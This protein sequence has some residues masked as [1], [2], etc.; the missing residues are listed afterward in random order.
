VQDAY[1]RAF[2]GF[3]AFTGDGARPWLL[4][5]VRNVAYSALDAR[6][7]VHNVIALGEDLRVG[8]DSAVEDAPSADP[9]PEALAIARGEAQLLEAALER[10][11]AI[12]RDIVVLREMEGLS[13]TEIAKITG[14]AIGTVMSRLSR[15]RAELR[16]NLSS[17][18]PTDRSDAL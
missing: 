14:T 13:Y 12:H 6:R 16:K 8:R 9:S 15:A 10:L 3:D 4:A 18:P 5:I 17:S 11:P 7:R 2:R 1:L